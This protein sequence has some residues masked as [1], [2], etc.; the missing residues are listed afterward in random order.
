ML[1]SWEGNRKICSR[2]SQTL[3]YI[4]LWAET[5]ITL[6]VWCDAG[7]RQQECLVQMRQRFVL[8][9]WLRRHDPFS[10][11][12]SL[13]SELRGRPG[14]VCVFLSQLFTCGFVLPKIW[15]ICSEKNR[16]ERGSSKRVR[17]LWRA[18]D[19]GLT[20]NVLCCWCWRCCH[21]VS[22]SVT[23]WLD[24]FCVSVEW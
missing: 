10:R 12:T 2:T 4:H 15:L 16:K 1:R 8:R 22:V 24:F 14:N 17:N 5:S 18:Y 6:S 21:D 9:V 23:H 3:W 19:L 20:S 11:A 7:C 13:T